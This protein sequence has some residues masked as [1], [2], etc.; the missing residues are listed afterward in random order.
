MEKGVIPSASKQ[1][2]LTLL[3]PDEPGKEA[4]TLRGRFESVG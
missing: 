1:T 2:V 3:T 4:S